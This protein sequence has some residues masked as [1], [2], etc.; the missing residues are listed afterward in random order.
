MHRAFFQLALRPSR[1]KVNGRSTSFIRASALLLGTWGVTSYLSH[2]IYLDSKQREPI[3]RSTDNK[4]R[5]QKSLHNIDPHR[6]ID[7]NGRLCEHAETLSPPPGTGIS[8]YH[9]VQ[10]ASNDPTED[11]H[12][13]AILPVPSGYWSFFGVFDGHS[14]WETSAW[15]RENL[16]PAVV[17]PEPSNDDIE[18]TLKST[19]LRLDDEIVNLPIAKV[20][21]G[22]SRRAAVDL[23]APAH[24]GSCALLAF[25]D[26]HSRFL[27]VAITGDSR[28]ILGRRVQNAAG[29]TSYE[30]ILLSAEQDGKSP[31]EEARLNSLHPGEQVVKNGR[32]MG[33]GMSRAFGD[34][35]LKWDVE[36]QKKLKA[37]YMGRTPSPNI[38]TPPYL[39]AEPEVTSTLVQPGDFLIMASDGLWESLTSE[40][41]VGL[42][43]WWLNGRRNGVNDHRLPSELPVEFDDDW[44]DHTVRYRQWGATKRFVNEDR[45]AATHLVRNALGGADVDLTSALFSM[46]SPR[47]RTYMDDITAVVVFFD[48]GPSTRDS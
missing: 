20:L 28:A 36:V 24:A 27:H 33:F 31:A 38:K 47:A 18:Q 21:S 45:N 15:L 42:V 46:R 44:H 29:E 1:F 12:A 6:D 23:L 41:A 13:E 17:V 7:I 22:S 4:L 11:D 16:V 35:R 19:F 40:E 37:S 3:I 10:T 2:N 9:L 48:D 14:G 34:A 32:V 43:G 8:Q 5:T 39:T 30:V 26:S 25:Y